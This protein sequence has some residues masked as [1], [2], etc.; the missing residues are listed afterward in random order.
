MQ[1][2]DNNILKKCVAVTLL[3][4]LL[5]IHFVKLTHK[6]HS[7]S[8]PFSNNDLVSKFTQSETPCDICDYQLAKDIDTATSLYIETQSETPYL[9][10]FTK[11]HSNF[12]FANLESKKSRGPPALI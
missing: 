6:H 10:H 2:K 1:L 5:S 11:Y 4:L 7:F 9:T 8:S 3:L 12:Y